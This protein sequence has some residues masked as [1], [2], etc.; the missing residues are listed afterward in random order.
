MVRGANGD[1]PVRVGKNEALA[2]AALAKAYLEGGRKPIGVKKCQEIVSPF[3]TQPDLMLHNL[4]QH[5]LVS[6]DAARGRNRSRIV[7]VDKTVVAKDGEEERQM[8]PESAVADAA[9]M[10]AVPPVAESLPPVKPR[11]LTLDETRVFLNERFVGVEFTVSEVVRETGMSQ[12]T[13]YDRIRPLVE[14]G[15]IVQVGGTKGK[16]HD[17]A[18]YRLGSVVVA[19]SLVD[20]PP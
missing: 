2:F 7:F 16:K 14:S 19:S 12:G 17:P 1:G 8:W 6:A 15:V 13:T 9:P 3:T 4:E 10:P 11:V 5:E 20:D 18:R